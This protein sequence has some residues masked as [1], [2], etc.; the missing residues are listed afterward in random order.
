MSSLQGITSHSSALAHARIALI[1]CTGV[2]LLNVTPLVSPLRGGIQQTFTPLVL[3]VRDM[4]L[5]VS[6]EWDFVRHLSALSHRV[7]SLETENSKLLGE[8]AR[9]HEVEA[10]NER[11]RKQLGLGAVQGFRV[12][13]ASVVSG[14]DQPSGSEMLITSGSNEG[15]AVG[16]VVVIENILVG[17]V[18]RVDATRSVVSLVTS[19]SYAIGARSQEMRARGIVRGSYSSGLRFEQVLKEETLAVGEVIVTSG[20]DALFPAGL[21]L[22]TVQEVQESDAE[23]LTSALLDPVLS[24]SSLEQVFILVRE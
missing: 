19:G 11:L 23:L 8:I 10:E 15:V 22:G 13:S 2:I 14:T 7:T 16:S 20:S 17:K 6:H 1:L 21:L 24:R 18:V 3:G 5:S 12:V 9:M 4:S